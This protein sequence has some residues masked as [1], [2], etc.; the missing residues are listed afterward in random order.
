MIAFIIGNGTSREHFDLQKLRK[1]T[2]FGCN[3]L[4][5]VY[6]PDYL[7]AIDDGIIDEINENPF[8]N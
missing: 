3:A 2:V 1:G 5:R 6:E 4:Y 8:L 7:V